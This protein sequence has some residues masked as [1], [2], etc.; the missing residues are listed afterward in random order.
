MYEDKFI[1]KWLKYIQKHNAEAVAYYVKLR[2]E[3]NGCCN[4]SYEVTVNTG[5]NELLDGNEQCIAHQVENIL[6][7][8]FNY[9][10]ISYDPLML[11][12]IDVED[13]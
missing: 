13:K 6:E 12:K 7:D 9:K 4:D 8:K 3:I 11:E 2:W 1:S 10:I 5:I